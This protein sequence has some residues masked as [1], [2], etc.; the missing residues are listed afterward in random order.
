MIDLTKAAEIDI[1]VYKNDAVDVTID[2]FEE[3][4]PTTDQDDTP[5]DMSNFDS[6]DLTVNVSGVKHIFNS[7]NGITI[8]GTTSVRLIKNDGF[9]YPR[10]SHSYV[11]TGIAGSKKTTIATG[12]LIVL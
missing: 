11:L 12:H 8:S 2:V 3:N 6:V 7:Q 1:K 10:L 4:D 5:H 9:D